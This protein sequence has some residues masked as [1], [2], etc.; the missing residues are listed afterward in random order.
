MGAKSKFTAYGCDINSLI[1]PGT[2]T[3][4]GQ[5][6]HAAG[7]CA[8]K[9][10]AVGSQAHELQSLADARLLL[11]M[12][13][14]IE[15]GEDEQILVAGKRTVHGDRL[16][17]VTNGSANI[18]SLP[19]NGETGH[20]RLARRRRQQCGKHFDRGGLAGP[21]GPEQPE[22]LTGVD[23]KSQSIYCRKCAEA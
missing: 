19:G 18:N 14:I 8:H 6:D 15:L 13:Q 11:A 10:A 17:H 1:E 12:W 21:V 23:G 3:R 7:V 2:K 4:A 9:A 5:T 22:N 16:R 20:A